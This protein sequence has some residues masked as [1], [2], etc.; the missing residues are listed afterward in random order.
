MQKLEIIIDSKEEKIEE[1][2]RTFQMISK[3]AIDE[4]GCMKSIVSKDKNDM[5]RIIFKQH[6]VKLDQ[7]KDY[8]RSSPFS[9]LLGAMSFLAENHRIRINNGTSKEGEFAVEK[10]RRFIS[11]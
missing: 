10:A 6:W 8:F 2:V 1:L 9:A 4:S 7:L 11:N 5:N 3:Q